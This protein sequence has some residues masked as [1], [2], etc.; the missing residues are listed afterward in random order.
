MPT[1]SDL[2]ERRYRQQE[3]ILSRV[4]A[5]KTLTAVCAEP[6]MPGRATVW[7]WSGRSGWFADALA[8]A[9]RRGIARRRTDFDEAKANAFLA[10]L[11]AG[12]SVR[13]LRRDRSMPNP[14][15][16]DYWRMTQGEFGAEVLRLIGLHRIERFRRYMR[17][18]PPAWSEALGDRVLLMV[19]RGIS[20]TRLRRLDPALP[21]YEVIR[22]WRRERPQ[23]DAAFRVNMRMGRLA[24]GAS[25]RA[26]V[27][28][29]LLDGIVSGGS[30]HSLGGE[31][32]LPH[33][34]TLYRWAA[35][36]PDF[37][38]EIAQACDH[39]EDWYTDQLQL[40]AEEAQHIGAD[41]ARRRMAP[42]RRQLGR[43]SQRPGKK[44]LE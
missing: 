5:G 4:V 11:R 26:A 18:E 38:R 36:S 42:L 8:A 30:L 33:R 12:D 40:I 28:E 13:A 29:P 7:R 23:F 21:A 35:R 27:L 34:D 41:E 32:G 15:T 14:A 43:L 44:W 39:R 37:A 3:E 6:D 1:R 22:R 9:Q 17:R 19:G 20:C 10:R 24:R 31:D 2:A 25:K 16:L